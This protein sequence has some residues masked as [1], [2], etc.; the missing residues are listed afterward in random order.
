MTTPTSSAS[1]AMMSHVHRNT[2][3]C[4]GVSRSVRWLSLV[5]W[6]TLTDDDAQPM[7]SRLDLTKCHRTLFTETRQLSLFCWVLFSQMYNKMCHV[8]P[9]VFGDM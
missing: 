8:S 1:S 5:S 9:K 7:I 3:T 2:S 4:F 6:T